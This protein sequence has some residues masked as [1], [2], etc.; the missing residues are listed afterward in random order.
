[1]DSLATIA[2]MVSLLGAGPPAEDPALEQARAHVQ[3]ARQ[4]FTK[5]KFAIALKEFQAA[6]SLKPAPVL[7]F[8]IGKCYEKLNDA[9]NAL[10]AFRIFLLEAPTAPGR[11]DALAAVGQMEAKL[12]LKG[13]Q[14]LLVMAQ[15]PGAMATIPGK[16]PQSVPATFELRPGA[17]TVTVSLAGHQTVKKQVTMGAKGSVQLEVSLRPNE[18]VPMPPPP[19]VVA[20]T[21]GDGRPVPPVV[22]TSPPPPPVVPQ[23]VKPTQGTVTVAVRPTT[24]PLPPG[25]DRP[26]LQPRS[27][28]GGGIIGPVPR[29]PL[30]M[31]PP[32]QRGRAW[33]WVAGGASL[34]GAGAGVGFGLYAKDASSTLLGSQHTEAEANGLYNRARSSALYANVGYGTAAVAGLAAVILFL[35]EAPPAGAQAATSTSGGPPLVLSF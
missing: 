18:S 24:P 5:R 15:P 23:V 14:Q 19:P 27:P 22:A 11:K 21:G 7:W 2:L 33:T 35:V 8:N 32:P 16:D 12:R 3:E 13:V 10:R 17:Y 28:A 4:A 29:E 31:G 20:S 26:V 1:V 25:S 6:Q 9:P 34:L 30:A